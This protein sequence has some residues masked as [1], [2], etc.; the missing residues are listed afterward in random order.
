M[1]LA[2]DRLN[3]SHLTRA[4]IQGFIYNPQGA[5][6]AGYF[7]IV[8]ELGEVEAKSIA[9]ASQL[10]LLPGKAYAW[11]KKSV[12]KATLDRIRAS[13]GAHHKL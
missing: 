10:A 5:L 12:R 7:D 8:A 13:L 1:E 6:E 11:N 9:V 2:R 4:M 3:P